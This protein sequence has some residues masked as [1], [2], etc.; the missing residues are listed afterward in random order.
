LLFEERINLVLRARCNG[1]AGLLKLSFS[2]QLLVEKFLPFGDLAR[3]DTL[4]PIH[5]KCVA[6]VLLATNESRD[7]L[8]RLN[9]RI[10][11]FL[12]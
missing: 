9:A 12:G 2:D 7:S 3:C 8:L 5:R 6:L 4:K 11:R 1:D 10:R